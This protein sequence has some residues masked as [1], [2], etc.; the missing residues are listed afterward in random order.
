[1]KNILLIIA[2][3]SLMAAGCNQTGKKMN[4]TA[5][6]F[7][8]EYTTPFQVPP[9]NEIQDEHYLPAFEKGI[10]MHKE[11]IEEIINN[12]E[13]P[14][15]ENTI[16]AL[17]RS[18]EQLGKVQYVFNGVLSS[19]TNEQIQEIAQKVAP[20][21]S[22]H[23]DDINLNPDLFK[24]VKTVYEKRKEMDLNVEQKTLLDETYKNFVRGGA[25]LDDDKQSRF[26]EINQK[27]SVLSLKFGDNILSENNQ[28]KLIID[29][30]NDLAGLPYGVI[31]GAA[32][33]AKAAGQD[34]KWLF[35]T[36]KPSMIPFLQYA[37]NRELREKLHKAYCARGDNRNELDNNNILIEMARLRLERAQLLGYE[38]HAHFVLEKR[39]AKKPE[40]VYNLLNPI[41]EAALPVSK[42]EVAEM[43]SLITREGGD[44]ELAH[45]DWWYYAEKLRKEKY[46]LDEE[47][48][49]P[50]FEL[51]N[52]RNGLFQVCTNLYGITFE[53]LHDIPKYHADAQVFEV[54]EADGSHLGVLYMD[55][56]PRASKRGGA[57]MEA[58]R[59][60]Y[61]KNGENITPV[62]TTVFNFSKPTGDKPALLSFEEVST[63]FHEMGHALHGLFS[64]CTYESISGTSVPWDFVELPSSIMENWASEP[65]VMKM[66]GK[67]FETGETIPDEL[68]QK[69][70]N[71]GHFN[72]G[73]V[74]VEYLSAAFLDMNWHTLKDTKSKIDVDQFESKALADIGL[75]PEIVVRYR[76]TYFS[77][78]FSGGYSAGYYSY[79]WSEVLDA[80]AFDAF[81]ETSLFDAETA[82]SFRENILARGGTEDPM[83]LYKRFRGREPSIDPL[84]KRSGLSKP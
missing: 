21:E 9:F 12:P 23:F 36:H 66:Y 39:M 45:W 22:G 34:G 70:K 78:I 43:Q 31:A 33:A 64:D 15:F 74:N 18:G 1:M 55:F 57:W 4:D 54:K 48:L 71:A 75:I 76:S 50:Y 47:E 67:H 19:T 56:H 84:L 49:R 77:H 6:P 25:E 68:I 51:E 82:G 46:D 44:F 72:Q 69:I 61:N 2:A 60:Q 62:I 81:K 20:M 10:A 5:N 32:E 24:R 30:E 58:Y 17:D 63:M 8:I 28:Y 16:A 13:K 7:F 40:D 65:E 79:K 27:I 11:E 53:E 3:T 38:T 59:K 37:E 26:R 41:W 83:I 29:D 14:D 73:F 80:D 35:T 42:N 52:V